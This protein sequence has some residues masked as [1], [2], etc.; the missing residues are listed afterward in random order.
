MDGI[1]SGR[2]R[3]GVDVPHDAL[4]AL[5]IRPVGATICRAPVHSIHHSRCRQTRNELQAGL[6]APATRR[7]TEPRLAPLPRRGGFRSAHAPRA[8]SACTLGHPTLRSSPARCSASCA[9]RAPPRGSGVR[10]GARRESQPERTDL[11]ALV[12]PCHRAPLGAVVGVRGRDC[13]AAGGHRAHRGRYGEPRRARRQPSTT[14][15]SHGVG[16][17]RVL[18]RDR[19]HHVPFAHRHVVRE[20]TQ[21]PQLG[22]RRLAPHLPVPAHTRSARRSGPHRARSARGCCVCGV[23]TA[24]RE[25]RASPS[26]RAGRSCRAGHARRRGRVCRILQRRTGLRPRG[27]A[28]LLSAGVGHQR[29]FTGGPRASGAGRAA[30]R[31]SGRAVATAWLFARAPREGRVPVDLPLAP[32]PQWV[33]RLLAGG[34]PRTHGPRD[35]SARSRGAA[36]PPARDRRGNDPGTCVR[37]RGAASPSVAH[38][39]RA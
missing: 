24:A 37:S 10:G 6:A 18:G 31:A 26:T 8:V 5:G 4:D 22:D 2:L 29:R 20:T 14:P 19:R 17:L 32:A 34:V 21:T 35:A 36:R 15:S 9:A 12:A 1:P 39:R 23:R 27:P 30:A 16:L 11:L 33:Q 13:R 3:R 25:P 28:P 38:A 7:S